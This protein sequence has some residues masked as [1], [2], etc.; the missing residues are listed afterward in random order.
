MS[1]ETLNT[2]FWKAAKILRQDDNTNSLLDY[3]EQISWIL[4][5][6][7]FEELEKK[8]RDEAEFEG[9][10]YRQIIADK[11]QWSTWTNP[12]SSKKL[13][14]QALMGFLDN[15][16]FP[17]LRTLKGNTDSSVIRALFEEAPS[18]MLR[19]GNILR[20]AIDA[21]QEIEFESADDV[22]TLSHL[23]ESLLAK[24][25][26]EGGF[27]GEFYTPRPI[28]EFI[29]K[30]V[31]PQ[32]GQTVYDP[33]MGSAG[34]LV[35]AHKHMRAALGTRIQPA[36]ERKLQWETFFG[37][38]KKP[39]PYLLGCMNM[40]LHGILTPSLNRKNTLGDDVRKFTEKD[41]FDIILTNPPFGGTEHE[42]V[43][44]NFRYPSKATSITF[45]QHIM[46]KVRRGGR[47]GMVIDEG[48]LFKTTEGAYLNTKKE[49]LE[50]FNL[51]SI[52]S[53]P[54]GVF[55][56]AV[57]T[58]TGPKTNL[59]FF[60]RKLDEA[61]RPVGTKD[62]W[63]Y[64]V[65]AVGFSLTKTQRQISDNDLPDCIEKAKKRE[66]STRSWIVEIEE[67]VAKNY[68]LSAVNPNASEAV[69]H[70]HPSAIA[71]DIVSKEQRIL[72]IMQ[73]IQEL[74]EPTQA[75]GDV[76]E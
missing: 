9:K 68:D 4:F 65:Q 24:L 60:E 22:Y 3:V 59:L 18:K 15:E 54:A 66:L 16:L 5:L 13:T 51:H 61:G 8:R 29:V 19:D 62:I 10:T 67:L 32:F 72:E 53:L 55:A 27:G 73:E 50:Q 74:L 45:L 31:D 35:E 56:N 33:A 75:V 58:G 36:D 7:C 37:Q 39:L 20:D 21:I 12:D 11:F 44:A 6:K 26:R 40:I 63:Y 41:R 47:V 30:M 23:Y 28:I 48:V 17:H 71:A 46:A 69:A 25:G 43:T 42:S 57:A 52:I 2:Q 1:R 76:D 38:E 49:L 64:E 14:G 34:F 70:R